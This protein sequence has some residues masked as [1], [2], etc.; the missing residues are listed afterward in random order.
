MK[1]VKVTLDALRPA[2][3]A[4]M[5]AVVCGCS[6]GPTMPQ[7]DE[8]ARRPANDHR[9][10]ALLRKSRELE[11]TRVALEAA[12]RLA[13]TSAASAAEAQVE[14]ARLRRQV[15][16]GVEGRTP[17]PSATVAAEPVAESKFA[18]AVRS[19]PEAAEVK[20]DAG[21]GAWRA[22]A[23]AA[24]ATYKDARQGEFDAL[25]RE[26]VEISDRIRTTEAQ[27]EGLRRQYALVSEARQRWDATPSPRLFLPKDWTIEA[28]DGTLQRALQRWATNEQLPLR[29][30]SALDFPVT[31]QWKFEG[32]LPAALR[33]LER[34]VPAGS[35]GVRLNIAPGNVVDVQGPSTAVES[36]KPL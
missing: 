33:A 20:G 11:Q 27:L 18:D 7:A 9:E 10:I 36:E 5:G 8:G 4:V 19:R 25:R 2:A 29:W 31:G 12:M 14:L 13:E 32:D 26:T 3:L 30:S 15:G 1:P 6:S 22:K 23:E 24:L 35:G 34:S 17:S 16:T 28:N 21:V